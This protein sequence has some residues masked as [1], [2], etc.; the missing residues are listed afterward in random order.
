VVAP[1]QAF[2]TGH[3]FL[4]KTRNIVKEPFCRLGP[5]L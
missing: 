4:G 3:I 5:M 1:Q 2:H